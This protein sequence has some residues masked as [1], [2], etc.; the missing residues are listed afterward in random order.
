MQKIKFSFGWLALKL[1]GKSLYSNAWSA[2]SELVANGFDANAKNIY[3]YINM[4]NKSKSLIEIIDDGIGLDENSI[5]TYTIVGYNRRL[6]E[7]SKVLNGYKVMGRKGIGKLA[8]LY[9]SERYFILS[10][11]NAGVVNKWEM[12]YSENKKDENEKPFLRLINGTETKLRSNQIWEKIKTGT[13]LILENVNLEGLGER[14]LDSLE[15]KLSNIFSLDSMMDRKIFLAIVKKDSKEP[16]FRPIEKKIAF[17]NMAFIDYF[18]KDSQQGLKETFDKLLKEDSKFKI[19][20]KKRDKEYLFDRKIEL[21]DKNKVSGIREFTDEQGIKKSK[22]YTLNGWI[23]IHSTIDNK[24]AKDNDANFTK[25][26]FYNPIQL[27]LYVRNKLAVENFL[28]YLGNTQ[29]FVNYIEGEIHF[30]LLDEDDLPDIATS[31][32]QNLDEHDERVALLVGIVKSIIGDLISKREKL[33][34]DIRD[35]DNKNFDKR[36]N[37]FIKEVESELKERFPN[38]SSEQVNEFTMI[39]ANKVQGDML[40]DKYKIFLS[41]SSKDKR[42]T[43]F[44]YSLL[45]EKCR[46]RKDE[47]F[48]TSAQD[49]DK[50]TVLEPLKD[51]IR[52]SIT[53][54]NVLLVYLTSKNYKQ[55]EYC[56]F[57]GGAGWATRGVGDYI[58]MSLSYNE[59]PKFLTNGKLEFSFIKNNEI[60]LS[61]ET[62]DFIINN[63]LNIIIEHLNKSRDENE[64][65]SLFDKPNFPTDIDMSNAN[66]SVCDFMDRDVVEY[67]KYYIENGKKDGEV[68]IANFI[69]NRDK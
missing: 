8:A 24:I 13:A 29:A 43:D 55:S 63:V 37:N 27:R 9:L 1:L 23:G 57:E 30:D 64:K 54:D 53:D 31:N 22:Q 19:E 4:T 34:N 26:S 58:L 10:K 35:K 14:A 6:E 41:H 21:L 65:I 11:T 44:I 45:I 66:K 39:V 33:A 49:A 42:F 16:I 15:N 12:N 51:Q 40:K 50:F 59:I 48:Y 17:K 68:D 20:S 25:N 61:K 32:R 38:E 7:N 36:K 56:M 2:I 67:W 5:N 60:V 18:L 62:Y 47:I 52:S 3:I 46:V 28:N 69:K